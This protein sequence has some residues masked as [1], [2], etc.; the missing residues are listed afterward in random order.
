MKATAT[1]TAMS[2]TTSVIN[3]NFKI[4]VYGLDNNGKKV[5]KLV[6]VSGLIALIGVEFVNKFVKR[7]FNEG[8]DATYCKLR[9]GLKVT[10]YAH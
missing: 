2:Y 4:K 1:T 6:G 10:F 8:A 5:N 3:K 7:A 9:R